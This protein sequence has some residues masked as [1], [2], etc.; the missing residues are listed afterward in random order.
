MPIHDSLRRGMPLF[1]RAAILALAVS[2]AV[3]AQNCEPTKYGTIC[4]ADLDATYAL[5][6]ANRTVNLRSTNGVGAQVGLLLA[7]AQRANAPLPGNC[8]LYVNPLLGIPIVYDSTWTA[9][10]PI[11]T[12]SSLAIGAIELQAIALT[13][14][15]SLAFH[16]SNGLE[17]GPWGGVRS[18]VEDFTTTNLLDE[19]LT[20]LDWNGR[21]SLRVSPWSFVAE[22]GDFDPRFGGRD[23]GTFDGAGRRIYEWNTDSI[24]IPGSRTLS[25]KAI[26]VTDGVLRFRNFQLAATDRVRFLGKHSVQI[27]ATQNIV[28]DG[29]LDAS[30]SDSAYPAGRSTGGRAGVVGQPGFLGGAGGG[31]GGRGG[32]SPHN[33]NRISLAGSNGVSPSPVGH[34][35]TS[36]LTQRAGRGSLPY[37]SSGLD[38]D[39][40]FSAY[41]GV[42]CQ[43]ATSGGSGG[44]FLNAGTK[45]TTWDN[46]LGKELPQAFDF[47]PDTTPRVAMGTFYKMLPATTSSADYFLVPGA[48]GGGSGTH[49]SGCFDASGFEPLNWS[50]GSGGAGGG[51]AILLRS[52]SAVTLQTGAMILA[53][54][55]SGGDYNVD[56]RN[57]DNPA[58]G[59]AGSG[60]SVVIQSWRTPYLI[61]TI[62]VRGGDEGHYHSENYLLR[63]DSISGSGGQG[64]YR[65][66]SA[67]TPNLAG[68][69]G[70]PP[71]GADTGAVLRPVDKDAPAGVAVSKW[72]VTNPEPS[73]YQY[74][75]LRAT[76]GTQTRDYSDDAQHGLPLPAGL[77]VDFQS[78]PLD[79]SGN[80]IGTPTPW[81]W[82]LRSLGN[83]SA[84][85]NG[86]RFRITIDETQAGGAVSVDSLTFQYGC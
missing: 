25:G 60:G 8:V 79:A 18:R 43:M 73:G 82:N 22:L 80:P 32:D 63:V 58:P 40:K 66:E 47:G 23:T 62:D 29:V 51:G 9:R 36:F 44:C 15:G 71:I 77:R 34:P 4:G 26:T 6:G 16:G 56:Q 35:L 86:L 57:F 64:L 84:R 31:D 53:R 10:M 7:G 65:I 41:S 13:N 75:V 33:L 38:K 1:S 28:V 50:P 39:V 70:Y 14:T 55:G 78:A 46:R 27:F 49:P 68:L 48:G 20:T 85:G 76:I 59:G 72:V 61:G 74:F 69:T 12:A 21:G 42:I 81:H 54:G 45:G 37:P 30:G 83:D 67:T 17:I 19:S 52:R 11:T 5:S 24:T 2:P 3:V